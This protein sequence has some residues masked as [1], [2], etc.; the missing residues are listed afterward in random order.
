[1]NDRRRIQPLAELRD[2]R[3]VS[4]HGSVQGQL[5]VKPGDPD[6]S[7]LF[8][9]MVGTSCAVQMPPSGPYLGTDQ[10]DLVRTWISN[11]AANN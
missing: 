11:G 3:R 7:V 4:H 8:E 1:M 5:L 6:N 10:I 9:T 2:D